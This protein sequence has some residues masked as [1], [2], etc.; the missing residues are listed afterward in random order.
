MLAASSACA[1]YKGGP[2]LGNESCQGSISGCGDRCCICRLHPS[3]RQQTG[4]SCVVSSVCG[5]CRWSSMAVLDGE[6][7][8]DGLMQTALTGCKGRLLAQNIC[9]GPEC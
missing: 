8:E 2:A 6:R 3:D 9:G 1:A 7:S 4:V 5:L